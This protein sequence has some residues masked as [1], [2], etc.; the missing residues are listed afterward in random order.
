MVCWL[1]AEGLGSTGYLVEGLGCARNTLG[2]VK[3]VGD[4]SR[5]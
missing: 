2:G 4:L 1:S 3:Y 5:G